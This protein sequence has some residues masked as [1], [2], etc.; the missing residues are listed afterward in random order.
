MNCHELAHR[1]QT[2]QPDS[3]PLEI[4]RVC[5]MMYNMVDDESQL[6][7]EHFL[8]NLLVDINMRLQ[9]ATDQH[10]AVTEELQDLAKSDPKKFS[11][12]QI[13]ILVRAIKVQSQVLKLYHNQAIYELS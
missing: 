4:A 8:S 10:H 6:D 2:L 1:I 13:W 5:L 12:D 9:G 11:P 7:N 3:T